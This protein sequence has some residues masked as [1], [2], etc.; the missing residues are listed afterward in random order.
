V[1][2][3]GPQKREFFSS[4]IFMLNSSKICA[5]HDLVLLF[6][7]GES[8]LLAFT[9]SGKSLFDCSPHYLQPGVLFDATESRFFS[10]FDL[11]NSINQKRILKAFLYF[12]ESAISRY[13]IFKNQK[14][15][16]ATS[17][18]NKE[19]ADLKAFDVYGRYCFR[20][21]LKTEP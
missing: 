19:K 13:I 8:M 10:P 9:Y 20:V 3:I 12:I 6:Y 14:C 2:P 15:F 5:R 17:L 18:I 1:H 4:T 7:S 21:N 16:G 11:K